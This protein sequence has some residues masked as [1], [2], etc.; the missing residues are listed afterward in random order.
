MDGT[1]ALACSHATHSLRFPYARAGCARNNITI[2]EIPRHLFQRIHAGLQQ[3]Q[4]LRLWVHGFHRVNRAFP[5]FHR[6]NRAVRVFRVQKMGFVKRLCKDHKDSCHCE[7]EHFGRLSASSATTKRY[8]PRWLIL[9]RKRI[10][11]I[12]DCFSHRSDV[13]CQKRSQRLNRI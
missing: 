6:G 2:T 4:E 9:P 5:L 7:E 1:G 11:R 12:G 10:P 8:P 3:S 13:R